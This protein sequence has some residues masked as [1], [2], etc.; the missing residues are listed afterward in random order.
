MIIFLDF[1]ASSLGK[2]GFPIEV[3]WAAEDGSGAGALIRPAP[4]WEEWSEEAEGIH[5]IS[6]ERLLREGE[7]HGALARRMVAALSGHALYASAPS[8]DGQWLSKLLR[9]AGLP[10]HTLRVRDTDEVQERTADRVL[11]ASGVPEAARPALVREIVEAVRA[12]YGGVAP[13]HRALEDARRELAL[14]QEVRRRAETLA[15]G[16]AGY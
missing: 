16:G 1:E 8:W 11:A 6:R 9:A 5:G 7:Q 4:G 13:A 10:R 15:M 14:W 12:E 2:H 3:G